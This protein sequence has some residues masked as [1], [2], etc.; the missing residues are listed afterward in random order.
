MSIQRFEP[1]D[2]EVFS[3]QTTPTTTYSS[4]SSGVTGSAYVYARRS[5]AI[6]DYYIN[7]TK[8]G[9][10]SGAFVQANDINE[11]L[12]LEKLAFQNNNATYRTYYA[13]QYLDL[14]GSQPQSARNTQ[15]Q[16]II[17]FT[18][19]VNLDLDMSRKTVVTNLLMPYYS[20]FGTNYDFAYINYHSLNFFTGSSVPSNT[21]LIYPIQDKTPVV[22]KVVTNDYLP[23]GAFSFDFWINPK[24]TTETKTSEFHAGTIFHMSAAYALSLISG[25]SRDSNGYANGYKLL[26]QL[27]SSTDLP[28]SSINPNTE[29]PNF[30][31][32]SNDNFLKRNTWQH[33]TVRWGTN[34]YNNGE[35]SFYVDGSPG[36]TFVIASSS[37]V[38]VAAFPPRCLTIGNYLETVPGDDALFF[39]RLAQTRYG[40]PVANTYFNSSQTVEQPSSFL[41]NHPLNAEVHELKI[42][43]RYL[44]QEEMLSRSLS[45][46]SLSDPSLLFYLPPLFT[47]ESPYRAV[48]ASL[49]GTDY[50][51]GVLSHAFEN[52]NGT[53][54]APFNTFL[55]FDTAGHLINLEN[56]TRDFA[57]G[58]YPRII[59]LT[60]SVVRNNPTQ[61]SA[62][63]FFYAT[64]SNRKSSLTILPNDNGNFV[65]NYQGL[66]SGLSS[67]LF[68][69]DKGNLAYNLVSLRNLY[70]L[71]ET[72]DKA[73]PA[74]GSAL[75][76]IA[77]D[78][79]IISSLSG[80]DVTSSIG[81][82]NYQRVPSILQRTRE[83]NSLQVVLFDISNLFYGNKIKPGSFVLSNMDV[84]NSSGKVGIALKDDGFGSLYR[85]DSTGSW[86]INNSVGN[87]FYDNGIVLL[88]N[89][90]LY[91]FGKN[92]FQC[93]FA[94]ERN[95]HVMKAD[96]YANP[97]ELISSSNPG[98]LPALSASGVINNP[99]NHYVYITDFYLH[100]ENLNV[101]TRSKLASPV[102]KKAQ[103]KL[104]IHGKIDF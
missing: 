63:G 24:Y 39:S 87:I 104:V 65:P 78:G 15:K 6:K 55:S 96:L 14:A 58:N 16:E 11:I 27:S 23:S 1:G 26:L 48:T 80:L 84:S 32:V 101:L 50:L 18:P 13:S 90:S 28:P 17:R 83:P 71:E 67:S 72:Y 30:V 3:I 33:V 56:H 93:S 51:G 36:G 98:W 49:G 74:S 22:T 103:E 40:V 82:L 77:G 59:N 97:L 34:S 69:N 10:P 61:L 2:I 92:E 91:F 66:L 29:L 64:G 85:A 68:R 8:L 42:Y 12:G 86:A 81:V 5:N 43:N 45:G 54:S 88:K 57:T 4:S 25:S 99:E 19:G 102:L 37:I 41:L 95:V 9:A 100:D 21:A 46:A 62:N 75:L 73:E 38:P 70:S 76:N 53:T 47:E 35:G 94:G 52:V 31:F 89:P 79:T 60:G 7:P 20:T 44:S